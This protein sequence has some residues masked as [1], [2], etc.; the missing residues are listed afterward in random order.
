MH[1][2][3]A[4]DKF[5]LVTSAAATLDVHASYTDLAL[6]GSAVT[7]GKQN[8]EITTATTT[9]VVAAPAAS[10]IRKLLVF[11]ARNKHATLSVDV[12]FLFNQNGTSFELVKVTLRP[13]ETLQWTEN[14]GWFVVAGP[15]APA[16]NVAVADQVANAADTY[17]VGS[18]IDI[19]SLRPLQIGTVFI[20]KLSMTKTAAGTA[21][22]AWNIRF[23][24]AG[25]TADAARI[26]MNGPAQTAAIDTATVEI[27]A[28]VR[29]PLSGA[30]IVAASLD[31]HHALAATGFANVAH[32]VMQQVSAGFDVTGTM[33]VGISVNPGAAG[34]WTVTQVTGEVQNI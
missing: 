1:L 24:G 23:G 32:A 5:Q 18:R 28:T 19:S 34:V 12:T 17:L 6:T 8:T 7:P 4:T 3:A 16:R 31:L 22:P 10:T 25:T 21:A 30:G 2:A 9:D 27:V 26:T 20:W 14:F 11:S 29:G 33:S 13:N 15:S